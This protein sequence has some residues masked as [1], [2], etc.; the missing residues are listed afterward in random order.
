[1]IHSDIERFERY[2]PELVE[3]TVGYF[4]G[5]YFDLVIDLDN[6]KR[7]AYNTVT[8]ML[9]IVLYNRYMITQEDYMREFS[10]RLKLIMLI[11]GVTQVELSHR[12]DIAQ[13][14][15]NNYVNGRNCPSV[16]TAYKL[17]MALNCSVDDFTSNLHG[18]ATEALV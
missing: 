10:R 12:T 18:V 13:P 16:Y 15:I 1:M 2:Y 5:D 6:G 9:R 4:D 3:H 11:R 14:M 8:E 7:Y 17:A